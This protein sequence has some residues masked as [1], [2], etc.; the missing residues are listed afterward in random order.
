MSRNKGSRATSQCLNY[1]C[2]HIQPRQRISFPKPALNG[3]TNWP[4][5]HFLLQF[6]TGKCDQ[7]FPKM[8]NVITVSESHLI[9]IKDGELP[10]AALER[11]K[12][13]TKHPTTTTNP[14]GTVYFIFALPYQL[15]SKFNKSLFY[16]ES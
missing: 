12:A 7:K 15:P 4:S 5:G 9:E 16:E 14:T 6:V 2:S 11:K 8:L 13:P 3:V 1:H 10:Q